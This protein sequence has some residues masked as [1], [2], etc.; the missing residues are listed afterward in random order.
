[1]RV[2]VDV[3]IDASFEL[4][5]KKFQI[6]AGKIRARFSKILRSDFSAKLIKDRGTISEI[7]FSP[8]APYK[9][10]LFTLYSLGLPAAR[11]GKNIERALY[12]MIYQNKL[13]E[14]FKAIS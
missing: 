8:N 1:M 2:L 7:T 10:F 11:S 12:S 6:K 5:P 13:F 4:L 9:V 14:N 3:G